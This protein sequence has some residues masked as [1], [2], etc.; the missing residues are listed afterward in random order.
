SSGLP[1]KYINY[2]LESIPKKL[3]YFKGSPDDLFC[4]DIV[5]AHGGELKVE[6]KEGE[7]SEFII[8]L[9]AN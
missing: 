4:Y 1:L 8:Q 9:M 3:M 7:G 5:K 2:F 6:T